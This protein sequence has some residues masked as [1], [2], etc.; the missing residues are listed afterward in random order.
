VVEVDTELGMA[1]DV[2]VTAAIDTGKVINPAGFEGQIE[3]GTAPGLGFALMEELQT[4]SGVVKNPSLTD[5]LIPTFLDMPPVR[6]HAVEEPDP[7]SPCGLKGH[8]RG[9]GHHLDR[10]HRR[11]AA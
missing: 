2:D 11:R 5:Y 9:T 7:G 3:G 8:R 1:R 4:E 10:G 6:I